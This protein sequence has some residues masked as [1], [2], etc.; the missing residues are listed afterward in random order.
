MLKEA[1]SGFLKDKAPIGQLRALR[2]SKDERGYCEN[3][4]KEMADMGW[5]GI[6]IPENYGGVGYGYSG[7]GIVL[8]EVGRNLTASPLNATI[9][10]SATVILQVGSEQQKEALLPEIAAGT[11]NISLA[12]EENGHHR[13]NSFATQAV[14]DGDDFVL[15]G[16][17]LFVADA[18]SADQFIVAAKAEN[19]T[20]LFLIDATSPGLNTESVA[21]IDS[22]NSGRVSLDN[23]RV[24]AAQRLGDGEDAS[25]ALQAALD[26][27]N[28]GIS[29]ELLGL[30][31]QAFEMTVA[32]LKEREQ[33]GSVIGTFQGLQHRAAHLFCE[34]ELAKS[35]VIHALQSIDTDKPG[36][37]LLASATKAKVCEV[38]QLATNEGIQMHGGIGMTDEYDI[39]FFI[40]RARALEHTFGDRNYHLDRFAA[41]SNY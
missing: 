10:T 28:I 4:W 18:A 25:D 37:S 17:K 1:A 11:R 13:S 7:L 41:L 3:T 12:I 14:A 34:I 32:Y 29:A 16:N 2:D 39:G 20:A 24:S 38:A 31:L 22:R 19:D 27:A 6:A 15:T 8:E 33:F 9:L 35:M 23:V 5:A 21:M 36:L 26:I 40:K 30:S